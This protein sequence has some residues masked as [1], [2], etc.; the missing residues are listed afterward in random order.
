MILEKIKSILRPIL[1][2]I[3]VARLRR[4]VKIHE[5]DHVIHV[6]RIS[7]ILKNLTDQQIENI[8]YAFQCDPRFINSFKL[9]HI[10]NEM[11][12]SGKLK[13][14]P[15]QQ[16]ENIL[17]S[18]EALGFLDNYKNINKALYHDERLISFH[19]NNFFN[20]E[21]FIKAYQAGNETYS[22][23]QFEMPW[24]IHILCWAAQYAKTLEGDYV[25]FGA[26]R[27][28]FAKAQAQYI[29]FASL[30]T[31]TFYLLDT[32]LD[33]YSDDTNLPFKDDLNKYFSFY[34][35]VCR[36]FADY[37][38]IKLMKGIT[39]DTCAE[40]QSKKICYLAINTF[41]VGHET[42]AIEYFWDKLVSKAIIVFGDYKLCHEFARV[43]HLFVEFLSKKNVEMICLPTGQGM[44]VKP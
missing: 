21:R 8:S 35:D 31:K 27:G 29:D 1:Y 25:E 12:L 38:N 30:S 26:R 13:E 24:A 36:T 34:D 40:V 32:F 22:W 7:D 44:V 33:H 28:G 10:I 4:K 5:L 19:P 2:A 18:F 3:T 9:D 41:P 16:I 39:A 6:L 15:N 37:Q 42:L 43:K 11:R 23:F 14:L 17:Y 20:D